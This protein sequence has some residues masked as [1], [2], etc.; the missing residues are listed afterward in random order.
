MI[1][2]P[3]SHP[4]ATCCWP[5]RLIR[6]CYMGDGASELAQE[7]RS[8]AHQWAGTC[9][10]LNTGEKKK[11]LNLN[12]L[13]TAEWINEDVTHHTRQSNKDSPTY[14]NVWHLSLRTHVFFTCFDLISSSVHDMHV[15]CHAGT[16]LKCVLASV[17]WLTDFT[18][19]T[20]PF[21]ARI[22]SLSTP[23]FMCIL[24]IEIGCALP[25][26]RRIWL[27]FWQLGRT[28]IHWD[29]GRQHTAEQVVGSR[30]PW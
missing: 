19:I 23:G 7:P 13:H 9:D 12:S 30:W 28:V 11:V 6:R 22:A 14:P 29:T 26:L 15:Y 27:C 20:C 2:P 16:W 18:F 4:Q 3:Q 5:A 10:S 1:I 21:W 17:I 8:S 25:R 24:H